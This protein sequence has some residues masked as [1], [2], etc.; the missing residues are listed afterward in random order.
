MACLALLSPLCVLAGWCLWPQLFWFTLVA[1]PL[2]VLVL[3]CHFAFRA[4]PRPLLIFAGMQV[5]L[6][7]AGL[8]AWKAGGGF[9]GGGFATLLIA[10]GW[11]IWGA[12]LLAALAALAFSLF[13]LRAAGRRFQWT[14]WAFV[15]P[16]MAFA[17]TT[18]AAVALTAL[19]DL[20]RF[21]LLWVVPA[22]LIASIWLGRLTLRAEGRRLRSPAESVLRGRSR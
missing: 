15:L 5:L 1:C 10:L 6:A 11:L 17:L 9:V 19:R 3:S 20:S 7:A 13:L 22:A 4:Y 18:G 21:H 16:H 8:A 2:A 14:A 12:A